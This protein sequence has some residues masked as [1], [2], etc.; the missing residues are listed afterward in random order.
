MIDFSGKTYA[1]I[2]AEMLA[3]IPGSYDKRDTSPIPTAL[4]PAAYQIEGVYIALEQMQKQ[5]FLG[6]AVGED[7]D[8]VAAIGGLTRLPATPAVRLGEFNIAVSL[9]DRFSTVNGADSIN[10]VVTAA[11]ADSTKWWLTAETP[12]TIG[13]QYTGAILPITAIPGLTSAQ[14]TDI[15]VDGSNEE[16]D[17]ELRTRLISTLTDKPFA[18]NIAAYRKMLLE[19]TSVPDGS[20]NPVSVKLGAVQVYPTWDGGGTV[21]CSVL[22][23]D[24]L[25]ISS[26]LLSLLQDA[27]DP[28]VQSAEGVGMAPIGAQVTMAT[29]T[30]LSINVSATVSH[31]AGTTMGTIQPLVEAAIEDYLQQVRSEWGIAEATDLTV[32]SSSVYIARITA[33]ILG[34]SGVTNVT[35]VKINSNASD[36]ALTETAALQQVPV[37]GTVTLTEG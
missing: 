13:N 6:T 30:A 25:P 7:L 28:T 16:T 19:L 26:A 24:Y 1:A 21:K 27:V 15:I 4:G 5:A 37:L 14:I 20:G 32:Y 11:T 2:L 12:G 29:G 31:T 36:L 17:E 10:F 34:V 8:S 3:L 23:A 9:G 18:G 22:G 35:T 33:A